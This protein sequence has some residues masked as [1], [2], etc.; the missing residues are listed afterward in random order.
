MSWI[1]LDTE[2]TTSSLAKRKASPFHPDN[3]V[4]MM[5]WATKD[6]PHP[7][8][9]RYQND[10]GVRVGQRFTELLGTPGL[11]FVVGVN[12]KF[13]I[14]H[15][16]KDPATYK[17][18]MKYVADGGLVWDLQLAEYVMEGQDQASHMLS[19]DELALRYG[20]DLKVDEVKKLWEAGI[21]TPD[22]DPDLL[23]RYLLGEDLP[24]GGRRE[25]D[26]GVTRNVFLK[27][28]ARAQKE[29]MSRLLML[30]FGALIAS[31]EMERNGMYVDKALGYKLADE[32]RVELAAA[33][34][35][36]HAYLPVDLPFEFN[37]GNRYHL[38][39]VIFGGKVKYQRR[40]YDL[41]DGT[42]TFTP[43]GGNIDPSAHLYVY[44]QKDEL[45]YVLADGTT[46]GITQYEDSLPY[47]FGNGG[48]ALPDRVQYKAGKN[49]G[50]YKTKKVKVDDHDKPKSRMVDDYWEFPGFTEPMPEWASSTDGLYSVSSEVIK[51]LTENTTIPFLKTLGRVT[52]ISKDLGT[53]FI[54]DDGEKGMLTLVGDDGL[55]H[56]SINH[57]STVTGRLSGNAPNLQNI[58]KGNKS[59]AKQMFVSRYPG[60][61]I[62]QSDFSSLEVYCQAW[63]TK[64]KLLIKDLLEGLDLH[65]VRLAA[66]E[67]KPYEEVLKLCKGYFQDD[68]TFIDAIEEWDYKRTGA[69]VFSFQRAYGA[70]VATIAK[71]TGMSVEDVQALIDAENARYPEIDSYF[72]DLEQ[73]IERNAVPTTNFSAHPMNPAVRVQMRISRIRTPDGK[74]Y[75]FRSHPSQGWQLKRGIT[76]TFSPTERMNYPVQGLGGQAMK[77]AMWLVVREFYRHE[78]FNGLALL[79]NT[80]HDA[81]YR[82]AH[83]SVSLA[84]SELMHACMEAASDFIAYWFKWDIP[85][86]VPT[87]SVRGAN[88]G[89]E[90]KLNSQEFKANVAEIRADLRARYMDGFVPNYLTLKD[91]Q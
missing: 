4:V 5:G 28:L 81:A 76:S 17:A 90:V 66:K 35:E 55:V 6:N 67:A 43:P 70:G 9:E 13:D 27:Q 14:L 45:H 11:R 60:G 56:H 37:W 7:T 2:T 10:G 41:K 25:G 77:S 84:S 29:G 68:G 74:R 49:A 82:D 40:Q 38:S 87:D 26:I 78:N 64:P 36:L 3:Y 12:I 91:Y 48:P 83:P 71:A 73:E 46:M 8:G 63:L 53:Y 61:D 75:T 80:V 79:V 34:A 89:D 65:C 15:L 16:I 31:I 1:C 85:L 59:K 88:M 62:G 58:P 23:S 21:D 51:T 20:E 44:A 30:E 22:I 86:P 18:W 33:K 52:A 42:T 69:K 47:A 50:E 32:L 24:N 54:S 39:P 72:S 57:T 19:M